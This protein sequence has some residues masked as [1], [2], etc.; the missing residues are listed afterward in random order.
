M[1]YP[2]EIIEEVR[3]A[4]DIVDVISAYVKLEKRG[5]SWFGLCPFHSEKTPSFSVSRAKQM[6]YCFGCHNGG[7]V[8][9]FI[10]Q[11]ENYTFNEALQFLAERVGM[12]LPELNITVSAKAEQ[13]TRSKLLEIH[14]IA[15]GYYYHILYSESGKKGLDYFHKRGLSDQTIRHFGL[16]FTGIG[17]D[18]LYKMLKEKGYD[19]T[20]I[21]ESGL[22]TIE[23]KGSHDKFWN[24]VMFPLMDTNNRVIGFGGRVLGDGIPK[25]MNSPETKIFEK[26]R[27]LFGLNYARKT[28]RDYFILCEGNMDVIALHQAG[29][30]NAVA[31]LGTSLTSNQP[32]LIKRYVDKVILT[33]DSDA[34]GVEA[35][36]RAIPMLNDAGISVKILDLSPAKD[37]DEF[38]SKYGND[39]LEKRILNAENSFIW[40]VARLRDRYEMSDPQQ[41]TEFEHTAAEMLCGFSEALERDNYIRA[42]SAKFMIPYNELK[43]LVNSI[44]NKGYGN[45]ESKSF[46]HGMRLKTVDEGIKKTQAYILSVIGT[47]S[48]LKEQIKVYLDPDDFD[49]DLYRDIFRSLLKGSDSAS[50]LSYYAENAELLNKAAE[51]LNSQ[52]DENISDQK[53]SLSSAIRRIKLAS[54][55]RKCRDAADIDSLQNS[56]K[57]QAEWKNK[58]IVLK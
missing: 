48:S 51:I 38:L 43:K 20:I 47:D 42:V 31:S 13:D 30:T 3:S 25:Y 23:E 41:K 50:I 17:S 12:K 1:R 36:K 57:E 16:G 46:T 49:G 9:T 21:K 10:M 28:R 35:A 5:S 19:D 34:A 32:V 44:G 27:F 14:K 55:E 26:N 40:M 18:R 45:K 58:R 33:Y 6:Y 7:N 54:I 2:D 39:E 29:F 24:R 56:I 37:P 52:P 8:I 53:A 22:V 4:N 11:Y 15:A